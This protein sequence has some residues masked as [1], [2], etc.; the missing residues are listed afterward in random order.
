MLVFLIKVE[1][2]GWYICRDWDY[3]VDQVFYKRHMYLNVVFYN[4]YINMKK[5]VIGGKSFQSY[6]RMIIFGLHY[7]YIPSFYSPTSISFL[8]I[9]CMLSP[10]LLSS[11]L[12]FLPLIFI[13][14]TFSIFQAKFMEISIFIFSISL[15][16]HNVIIT[17]LRYSLIS[18]N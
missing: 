11:L 5:F 16:S 8:L 17:L 9:V 7:L 18:V 15:V 4:R 10:L 1:E 6:N 14:T 2:L 12:Y 13:T 3:E